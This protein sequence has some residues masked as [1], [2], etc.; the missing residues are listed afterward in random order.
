MRLHGSSRSENLRKLERLAS[1]LSQF[2]GKFQVLSKKLRRVLVMGL[3]GRTMS[4]KEY[5]ESAV[6]SAHFM[7]NICTVRANNFVKYAQ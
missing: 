5:A 4:V 3:K 2:F 1:Y 6:H 7:R